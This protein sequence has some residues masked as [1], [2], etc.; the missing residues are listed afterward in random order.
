MM[1]LLYVEYD[2]HGIEL[3]RYVL[4]HDD[5]KHRRTLGERCRLA[6]EQGHGVFT[7]PTLLGHIDD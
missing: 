6:F 1:M 7:V 3:G 4:D 2:E 5:D